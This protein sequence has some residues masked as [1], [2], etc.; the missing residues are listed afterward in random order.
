VSLFTRVES[1]VCLFGR[2][3]APTPCKS[4][5][6]LNTYVAVRDA[7][8]CLAS[9]E[10]AR[11]VLPDLIRL[12]YAAVTR[13]LKRGLPQSEQDTKETK[14]SCMRALL[15]LRKQKITLE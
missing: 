9:L 10:P 15:A 3:D 13:Q 6:I 14:E 5:V 7:T 1:A 11:D 4:E 12:P 2:A 8:Y